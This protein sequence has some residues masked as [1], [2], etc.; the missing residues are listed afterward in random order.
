MAHRTALEK[1]NTRQIVFSNMIDIEA[2]VELLVRKG[3]I[4]WQ[5]IYQEVELVCSD[6]AKKACGAEEINP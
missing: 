5:E 4:T 6:M 1:G 3:L 2:L